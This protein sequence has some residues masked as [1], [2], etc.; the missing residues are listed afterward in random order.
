MLGR[1]MPSTRQPSV[2]PL[3]PLSLLQA[4]RTGDRPEDNAEAEYVPELLN[5]RLG[6]S[7]TVHAQIGRYT[8]AARRGQRVPP[9]DVVALARLIG[10]RADAESVFRAAGRETAR[11]AY[12][13]LS[14]V[15]R[16]LLRWMPGFVARPLALHRARRIVRRYF[17]ATLTRDGAS[18]S[19]SMDGAL[20]TGSAAGDVGAAYYG[21]ALRELLRLLVNAPGAVEYVHRESRGEGRPEWRADWRPHARG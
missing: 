14:M 15:T 19:M 1:T 7:D 5:K 3:I 21:E 18:L 9:A 13:R 11:A 6:T 20:T 4:V 17:G 16:S 8:E 2:D 10:R 12:R